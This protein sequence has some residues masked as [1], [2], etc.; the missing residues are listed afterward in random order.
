MEINN[1]FVDKKVALKETKEDE[2]LISR[3]LEMSQD[4]I[5]INQVKKNITTV[6]FL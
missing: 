1:K 5:L 6:V 2:R 4:N 3:T